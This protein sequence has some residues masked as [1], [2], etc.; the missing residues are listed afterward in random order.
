TSSEIKNVASFYKNNRVFYNET[1][2]ETIDGKLE[3]PEE[4]FFG[5]DN[6][7][8]M[9]QKYTIK[10]SGLSQIINTFHANIYKTDFDYLNENIGKYIHNFMRNMDIPLPELDSSSVLT[11]MNLLLLKDV[12]STGALKESADSYDFNDKK[13][14][15]LIGNYEDGMVYEE[16]SFKSFYIT[17]KNGYKL[18]F[19]VPKDSHPLNE[20][21][22]KEL[23]EKIV[24]ATYKTSNNDVYYKTRCIFPEFRISSSESLKDVCKSMGISEIF[25]P[26]SEY[27][28][29]DD[30]GN[31]INDIKQNIYLDVNKNGIDAGAI[32]YSSIFGNP[33]KK[34]EYN[35]FIIDR[36]FGFMITE[37]ETNILLF[38]GTI[39]NV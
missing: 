37:L 30:K 29:F 35:D 10:T 23:L 33:S 31:F 21:F 38:S 13:M 20:V 17:T 19:V 11:I 22:H 1:I 5:I 14:K 16:E 28:V 24:S 25:S 4:G 8:W 18:T 39:H 9:N 36:S 2:E 27:I 15:M 32:T 7:I 6:S 12:W 26:T 3:A 34:I